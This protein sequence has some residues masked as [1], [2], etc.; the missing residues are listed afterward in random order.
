MIPGVYLRSEFMQV[1]VWILEGLE[2]KLFELSV[3]RIKF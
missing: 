1:Q 2:I 3:H